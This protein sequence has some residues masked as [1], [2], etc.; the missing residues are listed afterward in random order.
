MDIL[1]DINGKTIG[2]VGG[3][4]LNS[5]VEDS[6]RLVET[7]IYGIEKIK[8]DHMDYLIMEELPLFN[9]SE[10]ELIEYSTNL[11]ILDGQPALMTTLPLVLKDIQRITKEDLRKKEVLIIGNGDKL[12]EEL[13]CTL[14]K[15]I[16]F[17]T[18]VGDDE[19]AIEN[20]SQ[21]VFKRTGISIFCSRNIDKILTNYSII[22]NLKEE[23]PIN[24]NKFRRGAI[25][26]DF[27]TRKGFSRNIK[28]RRSS[29]VIEDFMF[30]SRDLNIMDNQWTNELIS[31]KFYELFY[32]HM[33]IKPKGF[34]VNDNIYAME[35]LIDKE[36]RKKGEL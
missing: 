17:V 21:S 33:D 34:L 11:K 23:N 1:Y 7:F 30:A 5:N 9:R 6:K 18:L 14:H 27:S 10:I 13:I 19:V 28:N 4:L 16:S 26:F 32:D 12:I 31:S 15:E 20:I 29:V 2:K 36:I 25:I 22:V 35:D 8:E 24:V 3:I